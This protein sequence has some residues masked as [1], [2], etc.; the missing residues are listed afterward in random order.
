MIKTYE[1][2][3]YP[4]IRS[5]DQ[6][7]AVA[8]RRPVVIGGAGP[9]GMAMA[10]DLALHRIPVVVLDDNNTVSFGSRAVC[11]AKRLLE[12]MDRLGIGERLMQK[13]VTWNVGKVFF[14]E[15]PVYSFNM[16]PEEHHRRPGFI[17][18][19]QY[20]IEEYLVDRIQQLDEVDLRWKNRITALEQNDEGV[21]LTVETPDGP[22]RL[23]ADYLIACDG[24]NSDIRTMC[25]LKSSGQIFEDR[26]LIADVVMDPKRFPPERW[27]WFNP[28]FHDGQSTLL[29]RQPDNVWRIDFD[30]GWD[31]DP[32]EEKKPEKIIPRVKAFLGDDVEF[33]LDWASV[34]TF[35][36]R[37]MDD[38]RHGRILFAGDSAHQVSPFG[39]RGANSG[40]QDTDNL[41]WK[42]ALVL[43]GQAPESLLDTYTEERLFAADEN[44]K[45][46]TRSTDFITPKNE[47]SRQFRDAVLNLSRR[48]PFAR[49]LVNSGRLSVPS[50]YV[51]SSLNTPDRETFSGN[52]VPGTPSTDGPVLR[53]GREDFLLS[54]LG[55]DFKT[56][57]FIDPRNP[58]SAGELQQLALLA[59]LE[60]P[61]QT[62]LVSSQPLGLVLPQGVELLV[63]TLGV[64]VERFDGQ[65][66][67][68]YLMRPDQHVCG[69]MRTFDADRLVAMQ[70]RA[71]GY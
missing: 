49:S 28:P 36:C 63:D 61:I 2:P 19:Q 53:N 55:N 44:I 50:A 8:V 12:V 35:C 66:G 13:G 40:V 39:A 69:R 67:S 58:P 68:C 16:L 59:E 57:W 1:F 45:N 3:Q 18:L 9:V 64:V 21:L 22:Y 31:A 43:N 4:Y 20:Y 33:E 54:C 32:E 6:D 47:A 5:A 62:L 34:Y 11:Y 71:I 52:M 25:G 7:A 23:E 48:Y 17:N 60:L 10:I 15:A 65:P 51:D 26:F 56:L 14:E 70:R 41:A 27:F 42:L 29:H 24:A 46:S 30:L 37:R 38:F